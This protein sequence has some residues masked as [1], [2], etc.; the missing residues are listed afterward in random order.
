MQEVNSRGTTIFSWLR[1]NVKLR[2]A[3]IIA[4]FQT[5]ALRPYSAPALLAF[6]GSS[7]PC[8]AHGAIESQ[9]S[10]SKSS[11]MDDFG[12][13]TQPGVQREDSPPRLSARSWFAC[14]SASFWLSTV[15]CRDLTRCR[16]ACN[17]L[18]SLQIFS[19][20]VST[21]SE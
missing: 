4:E 12:A 5:E 7:A 9:N 6:N 13:P 11:F 17:S 10:S 1:S 3:A 16:A 19:A 18:S 8:P 15:P 2:I 20:S 14:C 21:L